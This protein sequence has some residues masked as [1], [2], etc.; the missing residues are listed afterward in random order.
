MQIAYDG[1]WN[2]HEGVRTT[3]EGAWT[4]HEDVWI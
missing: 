4:V 3:Y 2:V 1:V